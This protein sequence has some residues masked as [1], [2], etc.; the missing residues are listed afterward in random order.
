[1]YREATPEQLENFYPRSKVG[2]DGEQLSK[3]TDSVFNLVVQDKISIERGVVIS[4]VAP[5]NQESF[6]KYIANVEKSGAIKMTQKGLIELANTINRGAVAS[7]TVEIF[8]LFGST[9]EE[10]LLLAEQSQLVSDIKESISQDSKVLASANRNKEVLEQANNVVNVEENERLADESRRA[11]SLF[12]IYRN[13]SSVSEI[14][15][16]ATLA[17]SSTKSRKDRQKIKD[18][19]IKCK[20]GNW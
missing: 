15:K 5:E 13:R 12:D 4:M 17:L 2:R 16:T 6:Y 19:A 8:D 20:A 1:M 14:F 18:E 3:L 10:Q 9:K 7:Q 11:S